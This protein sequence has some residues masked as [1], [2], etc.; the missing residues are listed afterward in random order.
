[1]QDAEGGNDRGQADEIR[2]ARTDNKGDDPVDGDDADPED[3]ARFG[4]QRGCAEHL[5]EDVIVDDYVE[6]L[7]A[8]SLCERQRKSL[9]L[10]RQCCHT[11][12][13]Q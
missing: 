3:F 13:L 9:Y 1:M 6:Y 5:D 7:L 12:L 11:E 8:D 2:N 10:L 4:R